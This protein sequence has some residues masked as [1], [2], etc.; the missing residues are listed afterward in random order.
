ME[1]CGFCKHFSHA[2][3][4]ECDM[5]YCN[6]WGEYVSAHEYIVPSMD[7]GK[8]PAFELSEKAHLFLH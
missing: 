8:C 2:G 6:W 1:T 5:G 7:A 3:C 4:H